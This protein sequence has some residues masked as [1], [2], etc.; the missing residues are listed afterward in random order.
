[1][2][3]HLGIDNK[4]GVDR[5]KLPSNYEEFQELLF[6]IGSAFFVHISVVIQTQIIV[7]L[8]GNSF[9]EELVREAPYILA[10]RERVHSLKCII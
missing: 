4:L 8:L 6:P 7:Y 5:L 2:Y 10:H 3:I 9:I 1:M